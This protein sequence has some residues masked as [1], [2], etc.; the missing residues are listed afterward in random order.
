MTT[1]REQNGGYYAIKGFTYQF[2]KSLLEILNNQSQDVELEQIQDI[3]IDDYYIQ[4]KYKETQNYADSKIKPAVLQLMK[5]FLDDRRKKFK[6]YCYFKDKSSQII[7]LT[8]GQLDQILSSDSSAY[9]QSDKQAFLANFSLEFSE[10]FEKQFSSLIELIKSCFQLKN[11]EEAT[12]YHAI[13]R[14]NL[15]DVAIKKNPKQ[16]TIN[17]E[18]LKS[19]ISNKER[20]IF[21]V[22]YYKYLK[23]ERYLKY[24]KKEYFTFTKLNIPNKDRLF[25]IEVDTLAKDGDI[26][27]II[28]NIKNRYFKKCSSPAPYICLFGVGLKADRVA[29]LKQKLWDKGLTFSD[30]THFDKDKFRIVD[31][32][33][34]THNDNCGIAFKILSL[35]QLP[36]FF[37]KKRPDEAFVF[38]T[39]GDGEWR[40][41]IKEFKE[42]YIG[43]TKNIIK[44]IQ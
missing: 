21:E 9:T 17:Y 30:G 28:T 34:D 18:K 15:F 33:T 13:F 8:E 37:K 5:C 27:Q 36:A 10:N 41:K 7:T 25:V 20:I 19:I 40:K 26:I 43:R 2:D 14:A 1:S 38:L 11:E 42:F 44:I 6:L 23:T 12:T 29:S 4:V 32:I 24:L 16:R 22:A 3:G 39:S 31:L 35:D